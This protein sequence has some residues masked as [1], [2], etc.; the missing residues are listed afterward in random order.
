MGVLDKVRKFKNS[1]PKNDGNRSRMVGIFHD[2][3][4]G[5]NHL[6]LVGE[7]LEVKT[8]FIAPAPKRAE[9][10]LCQEAAFDKDNDDKI[11]KVVNCPDWDVSTEQPRSKKTCPICELNRLAIQ[12]LKEDPD[13]SEKKYFTGLKGLTRARTLLKWNIF[14]RENPDVKIIDENGNEKMQKGLKIASIGMEAW[15]DVEGIFEQVSMDIT[16]PVDGCDIN[17]IKGHNGTRVAYS[18][19]VVLE[20]T[21]VKITPFD[22]EEQALADNPHDLLSFC[23]KETPSNLIKAGLHGDYAELLDMNDEVSEPEPKAEKKAA[24]KTPTKE[25]EEVVEEDEDDDDDMPLGGSQKKT[26]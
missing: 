4:D 26:T 25:V 22:E 19:Q 23:G 15:D 11:A 8:H 17:I 9:R 21:S 18:A 20:G 24:T 7:F 14:D 12:A 5:Q 6:R 1:R 2:F 10:G 13:E 16:D 3:A